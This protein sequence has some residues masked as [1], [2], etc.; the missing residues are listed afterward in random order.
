MVN[1]T[2]RVTE[3]PRTVVRALAF[4]G[5]TA[6]PEATI[7]RP[8]AAGAGPSVLG[9][10]SGRGSRPHRA[11]V[12][13]PRLRPGGGAAEVMQAEND[14]Q[15]DI[16]YTIEEG[17]QILVDRVIIVG[18]TR[19]KAETIERELLVK[20]GQPLGYSDSRAA[21]GSARLAS[22]A[23]ASRNCRT[24]ATGARD[25]FVGSRRPSPPSSA[26]GPRHR[27]R[28]Y[29]ASRRERRRGGAVR[30]RAARVLPDRAQQPVRQEPLGESVHPG[31]PSHA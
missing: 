3:G 21:S 18:N 30:V 25:I 20:P 19:T 4:E 16:R 6:V 29:R 23:C 22:S 13:Q 31:Q 1:V 12:P 17:Q 28:L 26:I 27:R 15:A 9:E 5:T 14:T 8:R 10:R 2:V 11:R 7:R 24:R